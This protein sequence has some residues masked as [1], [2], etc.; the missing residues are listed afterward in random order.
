[1]EKLLVIFADIA[2]IIKMHKFALFKKTSF[3]AIQC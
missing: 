3:I 1:V 2:C